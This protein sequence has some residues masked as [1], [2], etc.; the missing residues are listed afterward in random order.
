MQTEERVCE[1]R[2]I[3][4]L[5]FVFALALTVATSGVSAQTVYAAE[6]VTVVSDVADAVTADDTVSADTTAD[7]TVSADTTADD[8]V[9]AD[10]TADDTAS[11]DTTTDDT[12]SVDTSTDDTASADTTTDDTASADTTA[13]ATV[14]AD[15]TTVTTTDDTDALK[16]AYAY[17]TWNDENCF[18]DETKKNVVELNGEDGEELETIFKINFAGAKVDSN[19]GFVHNEDLNSYCTNLPAGLNLTKY[20]TNTGASYMRVQLAGNAQAGNY[21]VTVTIPSEK[22]TAKKGYEVS[23]DGLSVTFYLTV[24]GHQIPVTVPAPKHTHSFHWDVTKAATESQDGEEVYRCDCGHVEATRVISAYGLW[25]ASVEEQILNAE[26]NAVV[27]IKTEI[28]NTYNKDIMNALTERADVTLV[29]TFGAGEEAVT[30]TI[31]AGACTLIEEEATALA[32]SVED[33]TNATASAEE[34]Q[35]FGYQ[36]LAGAYN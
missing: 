19:V 17:T 35:W 22:L 1:M 33:A 8:T 10:T 25:L 29:T 20:T 5:G 32:G 4:K 13:V 11:V 23:D 34:T 27:E 2:E 31:P 30:F 12:A 6:D 28:W 21:N 36:F 16:E 15:T 24:N 18:D 26:E 14:S 3:K 9:S 7:D